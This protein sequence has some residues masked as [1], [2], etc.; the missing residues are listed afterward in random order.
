MFQADRKKQTKQLQ[1]RYAEE[2][3]TLGATVW[4]LETNLS[5]DF[6]S[7]I[8]TVGSGLGI[9]NMTAWLVEH[10]WAVVNRRFPC[11]CVIIISCLICNMMNIR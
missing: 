6:C 2:Q 9:N 5:L 7:N 10:P 11:V 4:K 8:Q 1:P 3:Q